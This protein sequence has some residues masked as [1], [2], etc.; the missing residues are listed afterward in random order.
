MEVEIFYFLW[1]RITKQYQRYLEKVY[2]ALGG[3][4]EEEQA[5]EEI[6]LE[7]DVLEALGIESI[8]GLQ[9]SSSSKTFF[10]DIHRCCSLR[11]PPG[12]WRFRY[13]QRRG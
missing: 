9:V 11:V 6:E 7:A 5:E 2:I 12:S 1:Q 10:S 4:G 3:T 13:L 8:E